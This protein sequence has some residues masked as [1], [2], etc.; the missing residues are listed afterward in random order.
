MD[1]YTT[2]NSTDN[3]L[4]EKTWHCSLCDRN[5]DVNRRYVHISSNIHMRRER[6]ALTVKEIE[7]DNLELHQIFNLLEDVKKECKDKDFHI[8]EFSCE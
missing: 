6:I 4:S 8:L 7:F 2:F 3:H 5:M 1:I